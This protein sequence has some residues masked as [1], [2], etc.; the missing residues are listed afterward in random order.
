MRDHTYLFHMREAA[1]KV[2][3]YVS[4]RSRADL[5]TDDMLTDAVIRQ[6]SIVGEAAKKVSDETR[7][8]LPEIPWREVTGMRDRLVHAYFDVNLKILWDTIEIDLPNLQQMLDSALRQLDSS[9]S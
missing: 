1:E 6:I 7:N 9:E 4:G 5:E 3:S 8:R 2:L